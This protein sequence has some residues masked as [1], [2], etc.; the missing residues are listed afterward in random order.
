[1]TILAHND[2]D[3]IIKFV[4]THHTYKLDDYEELYSTI[5]KHA[6]YKTIMI[7]R[8]DDNKIAGVCRWNVLPSGEDALILDLIIHPDWR[9]Q[10]LARRMLARGLVMY[11]KV[12]YLIFERYD[13]NKPF[14]KVP[15]RWLLKRRF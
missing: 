1:M 10:S 8:D 9:N 15:V 4:T 6:L 5:V 2:I 7:I 3:D 14:K 12:R 11:P 13:K